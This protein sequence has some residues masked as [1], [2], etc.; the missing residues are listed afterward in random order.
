MNYYVLQKV[1]LKQLNSKQFAW[2]KVERMAGGENQIPCLVGG[3]RS[4]R[5][6]MERLSLPALT[7]SN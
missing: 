3:K 6:E 7:K 4:G 2:L 5:R 1:Q